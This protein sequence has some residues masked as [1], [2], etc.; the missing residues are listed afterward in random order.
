MP[1]H[2]ELGGLRTALNRTESR[3][4]LLGWNQADLVWG[5]RQRH[6]SDFHSETV[7]L[8][9]VL[10]GLQ[11]NSSST[12][13]PQIPSRRGEEHPRAHRMIYKVLSHYSPQ[14]QVF[15]FGNLRGFF[16]SG[17]LLE[18]AQ[19][20]LSGTAPKGKVSWSFMVCYTCLKFQHCLWIHSF[21]I[22]IF[23]SIWC[24]PGAE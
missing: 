14:G 10:P 3:I 12:K 13:L 5:S 20:F 24:S 17:L 4:S 18:L 21:T 16:L 15:P 7:E 8:K 23:C 1:S 22:R 2:N 6:R 11:E 19:A 9:S